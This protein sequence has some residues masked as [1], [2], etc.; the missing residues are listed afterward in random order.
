MSQENLTPKDRIEYSDFLFEMEL[1]QIALIIRWLQ[2]HKLP[3]NKKN[4]T[5]SFDESGIEKYFTVELDCQQMKDEYEIM[6][7]CPPGAL[8]TGKIKVVFEY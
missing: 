3:F 6:G 5:R 4:I 2:K 8:K 1:G 7:N